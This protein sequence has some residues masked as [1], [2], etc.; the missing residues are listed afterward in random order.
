MRSL[1]ARSRS[2]DQNNSDYR[3]FLSA[4]PRKGMSVSS[5]DEFFSG[6]LESVGVS[7]N[8]TY[9]IS[10]LFKIFNSRNIKIL[11]VCGIECPGEINPDIS[12]WFIESESRRKLAGML[13]FP[14]SDNREEFYDIMKHMDESYTLSTAKILPSFTELNQDLSIKDRYTII[15]FGKKECEDHNKVY[16][17]IAVEIS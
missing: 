5:L 11:S 15:I 4:L 14:D 16:P 3:N 7:I 12:E 2:I 10:E 17:I 1:K 13:M 6:V 9:K 8:E